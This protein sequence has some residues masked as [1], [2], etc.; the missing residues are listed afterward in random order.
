MG[1]KLPKASRLVSPSHARAKVQEKQTA[2]RLAGRVTRASG[3]S[4]EKG[5]VRIK[6]VARLECKTTK[7]KSFSVSTDLV[8]KLENM[9]AGAGEIPAFE[10]ELNGGTHKVAVLPMWALDMLIDAAR[11]RE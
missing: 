9:S 7:N 5:D 6:G 2:Q 3:S 10:I 1:L 8:D 4:Y 11:G